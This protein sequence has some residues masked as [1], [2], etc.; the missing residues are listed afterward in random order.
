MDIKMDIDNKI[1]LDTIKLQDLYIQA[2]YDI[3]HK[4]YKVAHE[5]LEYTYSLF[6]DIVQVVHPLSEIREIIINLRDKIEYNLKQIKISNYDDIDYITY[7]KE[8]M[9][10][11]NNDY[12]VSMEIP[13][14][15]LDPIYNKINQC[16]TYYFNSKIKI[17]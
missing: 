6:D 15:C 4:E 7:D 17:E 9:D 12:P 11:I 3:K 10:E 2:M 5:K 14:T 8:I 1:L 13:I 16:I